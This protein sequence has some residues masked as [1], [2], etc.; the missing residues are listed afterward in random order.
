MTAEQGPGSQLCVGCRDWEACIT[1]LLPSALCYHTATCQPCF[2]EEQLTIPVRACYPG[3]AQG[4]SE[5]FSVFVIIFNKYI[6][7]IHRMQDTTL[8]VLSLLIPLT[9]HSIPVGV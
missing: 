7:Y 6:L 8:G 2:P 5:W 9:L 3:F 4:T 1:T